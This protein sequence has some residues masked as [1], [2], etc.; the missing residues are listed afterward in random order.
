M[1]RSPASCAISRSL[2]NARETF[3]ALQNQAQSLPELVGRI[4]S[5]ISQMAEQNR[6]LGERLLSGQENFHRDA[7]TLLELAQSVDQSL[8]TSLRESASA[9]GGEHPTGRHGY[10]AGNCRGNA[11]T[12]RWCLQ[13]HQ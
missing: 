13:R 9:R 7:G 4:D 1:P 12:A 6:L 8:K 10:H 2:I 11:Q 5:V 3:K